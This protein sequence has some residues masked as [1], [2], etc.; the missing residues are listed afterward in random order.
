[1]FSGKY[2]VTCCGGVA[3]ASEGSGSVSLAPNSQFPVTMT[4]SGSAIIVTV[5]GLDE[6]SMPAAEPKV[7]GNIGENYIRAAATTE[8]KGN[9]EITITVDS[10]EQ[11][12]TQAKWS[13]ITAMLNPKEPCPEALLVMIF[14]PDDATKDVP[15]GSIMYIRANLFDDSGIEKQRP[16]I[17]WDVPDTTTLTY[18]GKQVTLDDLK[19]S[20]PK[21]MLDGK[22]ITDEAQHLISYYYREADVLFY[23]EPYFGLPKEPGTYKFWFYFN[24]GWHGDGKHVDTYESFDGPVHILIIK[25][26]GT[27]GGSSST[28]SSTPSAPATNTITTT[29]TNLDGSTTTTTT[30]TNPD[31]T[32]TETATTTGKDGTKTESKTTSKADGSKVE[33]ATTTKPDGTKTETEAITNADGSKKETEVEKAVDGSVVKTTVTDTAADGSAVKTEDEKTTNAKGKEVAVNT[34][35]NIDKDGNVT[36]STQKSTLAPTTAISATVT[37]KKDATG[38]IETATA[39]LT[40]NLKSGSKATLSGNVVEQLTEA[41]GGQKDIAITMTVKKEDGST[42][43]KLKANAEDLT[44][45]NELFIYIY[46]SKTKD[47]T[48]VNAKTYKVNDSG[49]VSVSMT[50]NKTYELVDSEAANKINKQILDTVK[51]NKSSAT[52]Q[53]GKKTTIALSSK[54]NKDNIK[55]ITYTTSKKSV[56]TVSSSGKITAK[57]AGTVTVKAKVTL[58]NGSTK[59]VTMKVKVK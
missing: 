49:N 21:I 41:A 26:I 37:V 22:D 39:A 7:S 43:Y 20:A 56:A 50:G 10:S 58:K 42:A 14:A 48:M 40:N 36:G 28:T 3:K 33:T 6:D 19:V 25:P 8:R 34:V 30:T 2:A 55:K 45:G 54:V 59:T 23:D 35:T 18:T 44:A 51:V 32:K 29:T 9:E 17:I 38:A 52:V 27:S 16:E 15:N 5:S 4:V 57:K 12:L 47:Y 13:E 46:D 24:D 31:G 1:M 11:D 53:P